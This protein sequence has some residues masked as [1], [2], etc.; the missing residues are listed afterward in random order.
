MTKPWGRRADC[1]VGLKLSQ[2]WEMVKHL[3][4]SRLNLVPAMLT[5]PNDF[6]FLGLHFLNC[7]MGLLTQTWH[8]PGRMK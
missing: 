2:H 1:C 3:P 8:D 4:K 6:I 7:K 5:W